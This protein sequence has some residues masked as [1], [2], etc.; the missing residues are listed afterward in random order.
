MKKCNYIVRFPES[1]KQAIKIYF[2]RQNLSFSPIGK[3][4]TLILSDIHYIFKKI[5]L[6]HI[7]LGVWQLTIYVVFRQKYLTCHVYLGWDNT[8]KKHF[9]L[10]A[11][12][13]RVSCRRL[14]RREFIRTSTGLF[15]AATTAISMAPLSCYPARWFK[16]PPRGLIRFG[17]VTDVHYADTDARGSRYYRDSLAKLKECVALM[18]A[19]QVDFLIELGDFKD[20]DEPPMESYSLNYLRTVENVFRK[21][22]GRRYHVLGNHDL[23]SISKNQFISVIKNSGIARDRTFYSFDRNGLHFIVLDANF[24]SEGAPYCRG[25]FDW[26]DTNIP[27]SQCDWLGEDMKTTELP[28]I[29]FIHQLLDGEGDVYVNNAAQVRKLLENSGKVLAVFQGHYHQGSYNVINGIHYY[30]LKA[31][32]EGPAPENNSYAVVEVFSNH[33]II[34]TGYRNAVSQDLNAI[35][36]SL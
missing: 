23:D 27:P 8:M 6:K 24:T 12:P 20:Q 35:S 1:K 11:F 25:N 36:K 16:R 9:N 7:T 15:A 17:L 10:S 28:T 2:L 26:R 5:L 22:T 14:N 13:K 34:V 4:K 21:F 19:E 32:V 30:T 31:L 18:N 33:D 29:V 3:T